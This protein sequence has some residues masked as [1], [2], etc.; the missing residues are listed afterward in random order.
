MK[1]HGSAVYASPVTTAEFAPPKAE[2]QKKSE[3]HTN[4]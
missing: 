4:A 3:I 1:T 2:N